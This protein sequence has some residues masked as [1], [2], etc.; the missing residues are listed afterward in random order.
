MTILIHTTLTWL[1]LMSLAFCIGILVIRL[2]AFMPPNPVAGYGYEIFA[3]SIW[4]LF[5]FGTA[6]IVF[7]SAGELLLRAAET[8]GQPL[9][10]VFPALPPVLF[11]TRYGT[12]WFIR[13]AALALLLLISLAGGKYRESNSARYIMLALGIA[14]AWTESASG[15][16]SGQ[17]DFTVRETVYLIHLLAA[18]LWGG[19]LLVLSLVILPSLIRRA[20]MIMMAGI[21]R[22]FSRVAGYAVLIL[23]LTALYN[24]RTYVGSFEALW[25]TRY[26]LIVLAK[27]LLLY[28]LLLLGA[29]NRYMSVPLLGHA[30]G[31][32]LEGPGLIGHVAVRAFDSLRGYLSGHLA[33]LYGKIVLIEAALMI[34]VLLC[35]ATLR[36]QTP[37]AYLKHLQPEQ[38][39]QTN[40]KI[41]LDG[42]TP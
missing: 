41:F 34:G 16:A 2:P 22:R 33:A 25:K 20:D 42:E 13:L 31:L 36:H 27:M 39:L 8:S 37:P 11:G 6:A 18:C 35:A 12:V 10:S 5:G 19:G 7:S 14:V 26:G 21:S 24:A 38:M 30:A 23:L 40:G 15:R 1:E 4:R 17:G 32:R 3:S 28:F 29:F 9:N